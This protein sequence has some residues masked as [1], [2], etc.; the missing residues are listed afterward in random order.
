MH[1]WGRV[2]GQA[3][4]VKF[5]SSSVGV[6]ERFAPSTP[7]FPSRQIVAASG[8]ALVVDRVREDCE[9]KKAKW[10]WFVFL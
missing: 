2:V 5:I 9:S 8:G 7:K 3:Q 6:A 1:T 10:D 4:L